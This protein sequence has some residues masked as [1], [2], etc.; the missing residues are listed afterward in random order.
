MNNGM[1]RLEKYADITVEIGLNLQKGQ[2]LIIDAPIHASEFVQQ[3]VKVAYD[4]GAK[5]VMVEYTDE[6]VLR[7]KYEKAPEEGLKYYPEWKAKGYEKMAED[8]AALLQVFSPNPNL[9]KDVDPERVSMA[10]KA[11]AEALRPFK[12]YQISGRMNWCIAAVPSKEWAKQVF[13]DHSEEESMQMLWEQIFDVT[14]TNTEYP[15]QTWKDHVET[16]N[17]SV[18]FLNDHNFNKLHY[19]SKNGTRFSVELPPLHK[20]MCANFT[21]ETGISYVPN[22]PTEEVFTVPKK[23]SV[24]GVIHSSMP[25]NYNGYFISGFS[26][27][28]EEG[29]VVDY[30]AEKGYEVLKS[31]LETDEGAKYLGEIALVPHNSP[32][33][34]SELVFYNTLYD[35]NASCHVALGEGLPI[36]LED[37]PEMSREKLAEME[38]NESLIHVD[39]MIGTADLDI[40]G[41]TASGEVVPIF[42]NG[43]WAF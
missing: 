35:E 15:V 37:G 22:I 34:N 19:R 39:F 40:D 29:K 36:A 6:Q 27:T 24:N 1:T 33:S 7:T 4:R 31:I 13:P 11:I 17:R 43:N 16:M 20:W 38:L 8:G 25:L 18:R 12:S 2:T 10:Q 14:R 23:G 5:V 28:F 3:V 26:L 21:S 30:S 9:L 32:I 42:R 41:E